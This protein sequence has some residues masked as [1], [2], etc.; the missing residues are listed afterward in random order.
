[1]F[2]QKYNLRKYLTPVNADYENTKGL[3]KGKVQ[4]LKKKISNQSQVF[5]KLTTQHNVTKNCRCI[6]DELLKKDRLFDIANI[7]FFN[8]LDCRDGLLFD[9]SKE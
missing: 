7:F 3:R 2:I 5:H 1:M 4:D 8:K 6:P 9:A